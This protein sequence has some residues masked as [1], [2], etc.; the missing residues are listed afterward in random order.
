MSGVRI[1]DMRPAALR[2]MASKPMTP[3]E[4]QDATKIP[5]RR[6]ELAP[7]ERWSPTV[8]VNNRYVVQVSLVA[9]AIGQVIHLWIRHHAGEMPRSWRELQWIK[10]EIVGPERAAVE[11]FPPRSELVDSANM[12]HLWVLP[13]DFVVPFRL[14]P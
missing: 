14:H 5:E 11:V 1:R 9:T 13:E 8:H 3:F 4:W 7:N 10:D 6:P 12:A 2:K